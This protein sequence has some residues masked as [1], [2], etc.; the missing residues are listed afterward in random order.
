MFPVY[1]HTGT[2]CVRRPA[3]NEWHGD[4][5]FTQISRLDGG[6][7]PIPFHGQVVPVVVRYIVL[8][9]KVEDRLPSG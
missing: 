8:A 7:I 3:P 1:Y 2:D 6:F 4:E 9:R 5:G